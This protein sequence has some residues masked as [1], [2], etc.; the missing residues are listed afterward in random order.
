MSQTLEERQKQKEILA[1]RIPVGIESFADLVNPINQGIFVDR[2]F[3]LKDLFNERA[4]VV[5]FHTFRRSGKSLTASMIEHFFG[6]HVE[7][8]ATQGLFDHLAI[9][10][11]DPA[12]V[13]EHQGKYPVIAL[14]LKGV[15]NDSYEGALRSFA[16]LIGK[17]FEKHTDL[18]ESKNLIAEQ[19]QNYQRY[20]LL[21]SNQDL[22]TED[23]Q[24]SLDYLSGLLYNHAAQ[25]KK[26]II[27]IDEYDAP[28]AAAARHGYLDQMTDFMR[29]FLGSALKTNDRLEK[30]FLFGVLRIARESLLS[31]LNNPRIY[32]LFEQGAYEPYFGFTEPEVES[33]V[34]RA[35]LPKDILTNLK[36]WYNGY[37]IGSYSLYNPYSVM[38]YLVRG[39]GD[40]K[41]FW[42]N[43]ANDDLLKKCLL[44]AKADE[45]DKFRALIAGHSEVRVQLSETVRFEQVETDGRAFWALMYGAGYLTAAGPLKSVRTHYEGTV[46]IPNQ[47]VQSLYL[48]IF[49]DWF[50]DEVIKRGSFLEP[51]YEA[52]DTGDVE[53]LGEYLGNFLATHVSHYNLRKE[54]SYHSLILGL[55]AG[56]FETHVIFSETEAGHGRADLLIVP[57][58]TYKKSRRAWVF[59]FKRPQ[60]IPKNINDEEEE[61]LAENLAKEA[62]E[63]MD[64]KSYEIFLKKFPHV[65]QFMLVGIGFVQKQARWQSI[66]NFSRE[67]AP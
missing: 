63:Q 64:A 44:N 11:T 33:L 22:T 56:L 37:K 28:M 1:S 41:S 17:L 24:V 27:V 47:E 8:R 57:R 23:L 6:S 30:G 21:G 67:G 31:D 58:E 49:T 20:L 59:E 10:Q 39:G 60:K 46:C 32:T 35:D 29:A 16:R 50:S 66:E 65:S 15:Q 19:K 40:P 14:T 9:G 62:L 36:V 38:S 48:D 18:L 55:T 42:V 34:E 12:F 13:A 2:S 4:K 52:I 45:K 53:A 25:Q 54:E 43:T 26:V 7:G 5:A 61:Q 3:W 51:F